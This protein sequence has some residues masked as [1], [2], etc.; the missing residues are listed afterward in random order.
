M[1]REKATPA[2]KTSA[3]R[4]HKCL[5]APVMTALDNTQPRLE[6]SF[7]CDLVVVVQ[8]SPTCLPAIIQEQK[9]YGWQ[10][11]TVH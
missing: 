2:M 5:L 10:K 1:P 8:S 7:D 3:I 6:L 4:S 9:G 11:E